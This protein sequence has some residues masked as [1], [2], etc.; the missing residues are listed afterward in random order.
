[1]IDGSNLTLK[2]LQEDGIQFLHQDPRSGNRR[3]KN[4]YKRRFP[5]CAEVYG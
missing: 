4:P 2:L 3:L 1:M 5:F